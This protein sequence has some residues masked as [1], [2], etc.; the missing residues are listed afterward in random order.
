MAI[1][2]CPLRLGSLGTAN[3]DQITITTIGKTNDRT[4]LKKP[5]KWVHAN[6]PME[7][8]AAISRAN[9]KNKFV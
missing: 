1:T 5:L 6:T 7:M 8:S 9:L 3:T 4:Y 2:V